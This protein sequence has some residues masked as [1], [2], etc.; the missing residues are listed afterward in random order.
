MV[1]ASGTIAAVVR[2][3]ETAFLPIFSSG[4]CLNAFLKKRTKR[5]SG[6]QTNPWC[7]EIIPN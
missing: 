3:N 5:A 1:P 2:G 6:L 4:L 7:F